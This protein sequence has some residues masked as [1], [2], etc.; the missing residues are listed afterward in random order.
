MVV[1]QQLAAF[2][3]RAV[4]QQRPRALVQARLALE[5]QPAA[6]LQLQLTLQ[7][8][9]RGLLPVQMPPQHLPRGPPLLPR[10]PEQP[11]PLARTPM[12]LPEPLQSRLVSPL[13]SRR[14]E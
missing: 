9:P 3:R 7:L 1:Q 13:E 8:P 10:G 12:P 6:L 5:E 4:L 14:C 2:P 11:N